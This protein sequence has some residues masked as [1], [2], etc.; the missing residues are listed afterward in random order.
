VIP[1][2]TLLVGSGFFVFT[3]KAKDILLKMWFPG[4]NDCRKEKSKQWKEAYLYRDLNVN[5]K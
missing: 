2:S 3:V 5:K 1:F 4:S